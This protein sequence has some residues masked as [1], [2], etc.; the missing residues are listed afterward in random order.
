MNRQQYVDMIKSVVLRLTL[1]STLL[2][3]KT[4]LPFLN[5]PIIRQITEFF[6]EYVL[7]IMINKT[8]MAAFFMYIDLRVSAQGR[9]FEAAALNNFKVQQNGTPEEKANAEKIL[10][11][12]FRALIKFSN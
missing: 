5:A 10:I 7:K 3:L 2:I 4:E 8:E 12:S 1:N 11:D 6:V 9:E